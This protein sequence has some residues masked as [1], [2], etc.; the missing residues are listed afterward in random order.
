MATISIAMAVYNGAAYLRE[1]IAS[2]EQ[3]TL[4]ADQIVISD[5]NSTDNS[6]E[7]CRSFSNRLP[8]EILQGDERLGIVSNFERA[9][10]QTKCDF[11]LFA[12]QDDVW[13]PRKI[14]LLVA[15]AQE[16]DNAR[17]LLVYSDLIVVDANLKP[18]SITFFGRG[19]KSL[20]ARRISDFIISNH[21]PGCTMLVNRA[22]L[23]KSLPFP[24]G[25]RMHD[26]WLAMVAAGVGQ[27]ASV[28]QPLVFY[29][30]HSSNT[31]GAQKHVGI[32][33][34][35]NK[36]LRISINPMSSV[37]RRFDA[38]REQVL[39]TKHNVELYIDRHG[40]EVSPDD[41][42]AL[43]AFT[44]S[45]GLSSRLRVLRTAK[46]GESTFHTLLLSLNRGWRDEH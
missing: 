26:W 34:Q 6:I 17:P 42:E 44:C 19:G 13:H 45:K 40:T 3:Q 43:K 25:I 30:Q 36:V 33:E 7:I 22:L 20:D 46:L 2:F 27:I 24:V 15:K 35:I 37:N 14:E 5:D 12:D 28:A 11:V 16:L 10:K 1:Q 41:Q 32:I 39:Y 29:R 9:A 31:Y 23:E 38:V 8:I 4:K 21:I 18:L